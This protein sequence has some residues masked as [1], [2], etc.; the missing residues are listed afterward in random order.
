M[1]I[2]TLIQ[3]TA[4]K[5]MKLFQA[6]LQPSRHS[7]NPSPAPS[8]PQQ[9]AP[10]QKN[11]RIIHLSVKPAAAYAVPPNG[12]A[13]GTQ[14]QPRT[15]DESSIVTVLGTDSTTGEAVTLS[16]KE[17]YMGLYVI[18]GNGNREDDA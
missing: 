2:T 5:L 14:P 13:N 1:T 7:T 15:P 18:R 12:H 8:L 17:R 9:P 11:A 6:S 16:L 4:A 10:V 3:T